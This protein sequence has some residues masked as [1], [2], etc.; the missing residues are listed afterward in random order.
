MQTTGDIQMKIASGAM[1]YIYS[2]DLV[3]IERLSNESG[4]EYYVGKVKDTGRGIAET[5]IPLDYKRERYKLVGISGT[6]YESH[7]D[8]KGKQLSE[9]FRDSNYNAHMKL[10]ITS[11]GDMQ[12][13][14]L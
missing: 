5:T 6:E 3:V 4:K 10:T 9:K 13:S 8:D 14:G 7:R 11:S 2:G 1:N 12:V